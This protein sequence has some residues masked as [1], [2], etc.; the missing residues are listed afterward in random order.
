MKYPY[1][2]FNDELI[3]TK[4]HPSDLSHYY[5]PR[6]TGSRRT[7][8]TSAQPRL[9]ITRL[10]TAYGIRGKIIITVDHSRMIDGVKMPYYIRID[11][12][13]LRIVE[14]VDAIS[15]KEA[16][17]QLSFEVFNNYCRKIIHLSV[18]RIN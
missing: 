7:N 10:E 15:M 16:W 2:Y 1:I 14:A 6:L 18:P 13:E 8:I 12:E 5:D 9:I 3:R 4:I 11:L 17:A